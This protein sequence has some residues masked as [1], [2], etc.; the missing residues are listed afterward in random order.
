[1]DRPNIFEFIQKSCEQGF[2]WGLVDKN[3]EW[4]LV[5]STKYDD[6]FVMPFW[7]NNKIPETVCVGEWCDYE[8][9]KILMEI[10]L[11]DWLVG[12]HN[13]VFLA[14]ID[15]SDTLDG[16]E[17]EPLDLLEHFDNQLK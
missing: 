7:S 4:A 5:E 2:V 3:E 11:D 1:M 16:L 13:D 14:G 10:F 6:T 12:M 15:W 17:Y 8:P 9:K